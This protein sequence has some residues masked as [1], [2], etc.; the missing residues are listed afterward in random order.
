MSDK[1]K[2]V[3]FRQIFVYA[4]RMYA[5]DLDGN[6][7]AAPLSLNGHYLSIEGIRWVRAAMPPDQ[8]TA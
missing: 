6:L 8:E 4:G 3:K 1:L 7:W 2:P 5:L